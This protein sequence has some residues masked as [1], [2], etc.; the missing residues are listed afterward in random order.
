MIRNVE[1]VVDAQGRVKLSESVRVPA[2]HRALVTILQDKPKNG[3]Y[4]VAQ[5]IN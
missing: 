3:D 5:C 1:A 4:P 2:P